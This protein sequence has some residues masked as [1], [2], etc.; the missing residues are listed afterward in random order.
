M[1]FTFSEINVFLK[2]IT[3]VVEIPGSLK[4]SLNRSIMANSG[5]WLKIPSTISKQPKHTKTNTRHYNQSVIYLTI[6]KSR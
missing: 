3:G 2:L 5:K 1:T 4:G 6:E